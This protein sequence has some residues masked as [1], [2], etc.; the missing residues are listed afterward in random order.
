ME[1]VLLDIKIKK[2]K[3]GKSR[4]MSKNKKERKKCNVDNFKLYKL[5][6]FLSY[7]PDIVLIFIDKH[8]FY[9]YN[10]KSNANFR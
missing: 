7:F 4:E 5:L 1:K 3:C 8:I 6:H 10:E 2:Y 9:L